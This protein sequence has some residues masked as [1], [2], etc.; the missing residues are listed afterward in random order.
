MSPDSTGKN[1][2]GVNLSNWKN[3]LGWV[4]EIEN[5]ICLTSLEWD[6]YLHF[7]MYYPFLD[8]KP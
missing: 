6:E 7:E 2:L 5:H 1:Y 4:S 3:Y 8:L